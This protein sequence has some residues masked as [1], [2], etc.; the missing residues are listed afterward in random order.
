MKRQTT[1]EARSAPRGRRL[2]R[3][4]LPGRGGAGGCPSIVVAGALAVQA[5]PSASE[6]PPS[7]S[8][9][10]AE[11]HWSFRSAEPSER[12]LLRGV[13]SESLLAP[14]GATV[15]ERPGGVQV[16]HGAFSLAVGFDAPAFGEL[17]GSLAPRSIAYRDD[18]TLV[19]Q[20]RD[21]FAAAVVVER[22]PEWEPSDVR[23]ML[24]ATEGW[25][26]GQAPTRGVPREAVQAAVAACH[27]LQLPR[28][29]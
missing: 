7:R 18:S 3:R 22:S 20:I 9:R 14:E 17:L 25:E 29:R 12:L 2:A 24:C 28:L 1:G 27:S 15:S 4:T 13:G 19:V 8:V 21:G 5:C 26:P 23:R 11:G 6:E 10:V 16:T